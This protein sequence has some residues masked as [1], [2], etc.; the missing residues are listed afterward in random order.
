MPPISPK[1]PV[2][3]TERQ[4]VK[5]KSG[6]KDKMR[7]RHQKN[8]ASVLTRALECGSEL[9]TMEGAES[10]SPHP[11]ANPAPMKARTIKFLWKVVW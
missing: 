6:G 1:R 7:W 10:D 3:K 4:M 11:A 2:R 5:W 8:V 9:R